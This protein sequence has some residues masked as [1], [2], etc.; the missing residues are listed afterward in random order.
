[1]P[2]VGHPPL[3]EGVAQ[4]GDDDPLTPLEAFDHNLQ[5]VHPDSQGAALVTRIESRTG[6]RG[7]SSDRR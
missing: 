6:Y 7:S 3:G 5:P 4:A 2:P 1:M